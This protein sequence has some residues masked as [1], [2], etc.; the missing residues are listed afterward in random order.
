MHTICG[1][2]VQCMYMCIH[3]GTM[4]MMH[5]YYSIVHMHHIHGS[6]MYIHVYASVSVID[7]ESYRDLQESYQACNFVTELKICTV[8]VL[9]RLYNQ[10]T[11][12]SCAGLARRP[13]TM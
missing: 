12:C 3:V 8:R 11:Y 9:S 2:H 1:T 10:G 5:V 7:T 4:Y 6:D 13:L